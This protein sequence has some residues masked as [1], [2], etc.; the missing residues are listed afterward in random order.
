M[1]SRAAFSTMYF[2]R[3][4]SHIM[5]LLMQ[6]M[7]TRDYCVGFFCCFSFFLSVVKCA[8]VWNWMFQRW[9]FKKHDFSLRFF[10]FLVML[11]GKWCKWLT[12][13]SC[14]EKQK[15]N[16]TMHMKMIR[17]ASNIN[18]FRA[19]TMYKTK[20]LCNFM[21]NSLCLVQRGKWMRCTQ[22]IFCLFHARTH[23]AAC[24][25]GRKRRLIRLQREWT[26][27]KLMYRRRFCRGRRKYDAK[28][29]LAREN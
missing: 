17:W 16:A 7:H 25:E 5:D 9:M 15:K 24:A 12:E 29:L 14:Q 28:V 6:N 10:N 23:A 11:N 20:F 18:A 22:C 26:P 13:K 21:A 27:C 4:K 8:I 1:S 3:G 2:A 19:L